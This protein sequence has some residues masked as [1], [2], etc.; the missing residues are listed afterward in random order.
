M[1]Y[2]D[3]DIVGDINL[4]RRQ[5]PPTAVSDK[6]PDGVSF[7]PLRRPRYEGFPAI[8]Q[9]LGMVS[10]V[11]VTIKKCGKV[12]R[13]IRIIIMKVQFWAGS[14]ISIRAAAGSP[15]NPAIYHFVKHHE[16]AHS[17]PP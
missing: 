5:P 14:R 11:L 15:R 8:K 6:I 16:V 7:S 3:E 13:Q 1:D 9:S 4:F 10:M 12:K 2:F 17:A